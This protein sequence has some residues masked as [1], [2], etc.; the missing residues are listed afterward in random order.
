M[1]SEATTNIIRKV[2]SQM[3]LDRQ[4]VIAVINLFGRPEPGPNV[5]AH[6][7]CLYVT[8]LMYRE[9]RYHS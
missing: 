4:D 3:P 2:E 5:S 8:C 1:W 7:L 6:D 9:A